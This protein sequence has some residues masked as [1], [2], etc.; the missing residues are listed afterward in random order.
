MQT[1]EIP[2]SDLGGHSVTDSKGV[3]AFPLQNGLRAPAWAGPWRPPLDL[4]HGE[5]AT[6]RGT[7]LR[8]FQRLEILEI[9]LW[10]LHVCFSALTT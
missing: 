7:S 2:K 8:D 6:G 3:G 5:E 9:N 1:S 4:G 10:V